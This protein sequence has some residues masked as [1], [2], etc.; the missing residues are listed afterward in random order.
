MRRILLILAVAALMAATV[1]GGAGSA[2][3]KEPAHCKQ[4]DFDPSLQT[5][6]G[7][8]GDQ[9]GGGGGQT[10]DLQ[11]VANPGIVTQT[12]GGSGKKGG[13]GGGKDCFNVAGSTIDCEHGSLP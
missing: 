4:A 1:W 12:T 7:G 3:A 2:L 13:G 8:S 11:P 10:T 5:C 6:A 9:S